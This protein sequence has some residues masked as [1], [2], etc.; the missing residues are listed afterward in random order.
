MVLNQ[1]VFYLPNT[2]T[3]CISTAWISGSALRDVNICNK[4]AAP[5]KGRHRGK[6]NLMI[7]NDG[8]AMQDDVNGNSRQ[9]VNNK[10]EFVRGLNSGIIS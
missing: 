4:L 6:C 10:G 3:E 2:T 9:S 8:V 1:R 5:E 7:N